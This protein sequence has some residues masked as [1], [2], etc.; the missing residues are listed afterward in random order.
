MPSPTA[1]AV[2]ALTGLTAGLAAQPPVLELGPERFEQSA[3]AWPAD[4]AALE[5]LPVTDRGGQAHGR[6]V[7]VLRHP[8]GSL[9]ALRIEWTGPQARTRFQIEHPVRFLD[10]RPDVPRVVAHQSWPEL[11]SGFSEARTAPGP[12]PPRA[13]TA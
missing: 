3:T 7:D 12:V 11:E 4:N 2:A 5:T 8:D 10:Y 13:G 9:A 1:L 6:V